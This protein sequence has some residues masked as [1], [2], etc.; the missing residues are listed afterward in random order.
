MIEQWIDAVQDV[1]RG[2]AVNDFTSM[3]APYLLKKA[4]FPSAINPADLAAAPLALTIV[5]ST[6][7]MYSAGGPQE[8]FYKGVTQF[9]VSSGLDFAD[10]PRLLKFPRL[11]VV[12]AAAN[13]QLGGLVNHFALE[14]RDDQID[15]PKP[16]Q[17]GDEEPHWGF[18]VYWEV[19]ENVNSAITVAVGD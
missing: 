8:G 5:N 7:Y 11:I 18:D 4:E 3:Q 1:W 19:K 14:D 16:V 10:L 9:H 17:Y 15:G 12:A 6:Q 2:I 13:L